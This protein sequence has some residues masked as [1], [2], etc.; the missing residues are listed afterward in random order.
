M[1]MKERKVKKVF[2]DLLA[3]LF[4]TKAKEFHFNIVNLQPKFVL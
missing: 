1:I 4:G 3:N 2:F